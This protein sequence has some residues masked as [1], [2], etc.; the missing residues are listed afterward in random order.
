[1][2]TVLALHLEFCGDKALSHSL[3]YVR[4]SLS[5]SQN[6]FP[7]FSGLF[8]LHTRPVH[9]QYETDADVKRAQTAMF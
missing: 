8:Y 6:V 3:S 5:L 1:M 7:G 4:T 2:L 9:G